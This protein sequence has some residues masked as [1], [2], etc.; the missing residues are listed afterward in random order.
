[1]LELTIDKK[2]R[3]NKDLGFFRFRRLATGDCVLTNDVGDSLVLDA[4]DFRV[5]TQERLPE[6][7]GKYNDLVRLG[8]LEPEQFV[9]HELISRYRNRNLFLF[10]G[11]TLHIMVVTLRCNLKCIYCQASSRRAGETE[12]DMDEDTARRVVDTIL[13]SPSDN[14]AIE[15]QGGEPLLN[16]K[17]IEFVVKYASRK[18]LAAR[19]NIYFSLVS[20]L[21]GLTGDQLAFLIEHEVGLTTS[22]DGPRELHDMQRG[23]GSHEKTVANF[24]RCMKEY[25]SNYMIRLPGCLMTMTRNS[26]KYPTEIVDEYVR[27]NQDAIQFRRVSPFGFAHQDLDKLF[28]SAEKFLEFYE[29]AFD[30]IIELNRRGTRII[31]RT[32][33]LFLAKMLTDVPINH[34]D[35]R[36][37]CGAGI[38]QM[39]YNYNGDVYT[40]D[41][42][43]MLAMMGDDAFRIG[44]VHE[45]TLS[46]MMETD[47]V[48]NMCAASCLEGRAACD[49]CS[50]KPY[51]GVCPIYNFFLEGSVYG[52]RYCNDP[53]RIFKGIMDILVERSKDEK[54]LEI[55]NSW[56][57]EATIL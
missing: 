17:I 29:Q 55:F 19:K 3:F 40:C 33:Y 35:L 7:H 31:E 21:V 6:N 44:N 15:F 54:N 10:R 36:N 47:V 16:W 48:K 57:N 46:G 37:P 22:V 9:N 5:L 23:A 38:G 39:A 30:Y 50:Y 42:G 24:E 49:A 27:L 53:C 43:R 1:M 2:V 12:F 28:F 25:K 18:A 8:I 52:S 45:D 11:A 56:L 26:L 32:A 13:S 20:N 41:E 34:M 14:L 51:C 4:E